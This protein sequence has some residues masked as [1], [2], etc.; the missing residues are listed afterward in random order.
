MKILIVEDNNQT[1]MQYQ[2]ALEERSHDV[3]VTHNGEEGCNAYS[4][5]MK[6]M[7]SGQKNNSPFDL[8][9]LDYRLPVKNGVQVAK[10]INTKNPKQKIV[11]ATGHLKE[12][13][14]NEGKEMGIPLKVIEKPFEL[15]EF[16]DKIET[17]A[18]A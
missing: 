12:I 7:R 5:A 3:I 13:L 17:F 8:V 6:V 14:S 18:S 11:F 16:V 10:K 4:D 9:V 1:A 2:L 15:D